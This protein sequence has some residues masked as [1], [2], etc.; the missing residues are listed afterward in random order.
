MK[1]LPFSFECNCVSLL[2][3][4]PTA[5]Q[6]PQVSW[7][8]KK[9]SEGKRNSQI[10]PYLLVNTIESQ[11]Q[12]LTSHAWSA[13]SHAPHT[14]TTFPVVYSFHRGSWQLLCQLS[15]SSIAITSITSAKRSL[16]YTPARSGFFS[17]VS[18]AISWLFPSAGTPTAPT[19]PLWK[20][21]AGAGRPKGK[22]APC[23][24]SC[25]ASVFRGCSP[26]RTGCKGFCTW[27]KQSGGMFRY[28]SGW[29]IKALAVMPEKNP[30]NNYKDW[31][32]EKQLFSLKGRAS[33][34]VSSTCLQSH[35]REQYASKIR[36]DACV[37]QCACASRVITYSKRLLSPPLALYHSRKSTGIIPL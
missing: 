9:T 12:S 37:S 21:R 15:S 7:L 31:L 19:I 10:N 4:I 5:V 22:H 16:P 29:S 3:T 11:L 26:G 14:H 33:S 24:K 25:L 18:S 23:S 30:F 32:P 35:Q 13:K 36:L 6:T 2:E 28:V 27:N 17:H 20:H 8:G 34:L 1:L